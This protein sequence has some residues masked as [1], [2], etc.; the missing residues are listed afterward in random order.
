MH[1]NANI[2]LEM[3]EAGMPL[4]FTGYGLLPG[5]GGAGERRGGLGLFREWRVD[6][7]RATMTAQMDRFRHRP[8]GLAGGEPG[9]AGRL[10]LIRDGARTQLHSKVSN[11]P[12]RRGDII[13]LETSGGGGFGDPARR[14]GS[15]RARDSA[16]GYVAA[17]G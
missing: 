17:S 16:L 8:Y 9:S 13:R 12:L 10:V 1:N 4:S 14:S 6:A 11:L 3:V 2:P 15:D 5:S 7:E